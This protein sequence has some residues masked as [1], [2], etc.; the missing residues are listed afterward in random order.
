LRTDFKSVHG[1]VNRNGADFN[2]AHAERAGSGIKD[3]ALYP[4]L[5]PFL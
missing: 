2:R 4:P 1:N 5:A 3:P